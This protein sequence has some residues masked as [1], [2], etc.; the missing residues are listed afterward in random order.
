MY[1]IPINFI[2]R[3]CFDH[4]ERLYHKTAALIL[5]WPQARQTNDDDICHQKIQLRILPHHGLMGVHAGIG[6]LQL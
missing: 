1:L 2:E 3:G 5:P 6:C 4:S